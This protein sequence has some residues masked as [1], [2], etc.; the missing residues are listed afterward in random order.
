MARYPQLYSSYKPKRLHDIAKSAYEILQTVP[1]PDDHYYK[2]REQ[3]LAMIA[4][5]ATE[6]LKNQGTST[7][8]KY[9]EVQQLQDDIVALADKAELFKEEV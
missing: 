8:E 9:Y 2:G 5:Y 7:P 6:A 1:L 3:D 4:L